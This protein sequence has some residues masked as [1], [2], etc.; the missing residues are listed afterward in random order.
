MNPSSS[1]HDSKCVAAVQEQFAEGFATS[2]LRDAQVL[3]DVSA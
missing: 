3:L 1:S 2:D